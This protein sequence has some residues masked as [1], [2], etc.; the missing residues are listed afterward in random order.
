MLKTTSGFSPRTDLS[1]NINFSLSQFHA[2]VPEMN[3]ARHRM[4]VQSFPNT[5]MQHS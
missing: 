5:C 4:S 2:T 3:V 1:N